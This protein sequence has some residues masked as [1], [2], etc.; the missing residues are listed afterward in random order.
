MVY[1]KSLRALIGA[2]ALAAAVPTFADELSEVTVTATRTSIECAGLSADEARRM[3]QQ[4]AR[5]GDH[6]KAAECFRAAGDHARADR[7]LM[8]AS[9]D[10]GAAASRQLSA[11][12][13]T[14]KEQARR[15]RAA[16]ASMR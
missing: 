13:D 9:A 15:L 12:V 10:S 5:D 4:A 11:N 16:F 8:R 14:A 3:A 1:L 7:A 6:R 2:V